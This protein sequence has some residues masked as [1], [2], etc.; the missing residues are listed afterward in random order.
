MSQRVRNWV[1]TL[2]NY[3]AADEDRLSMLYETGSI[4]YLVFGREVGNTG[5][6]H[7]QGFVQWKE[8]QSLRQCK[9]RIGQ[10]AHLEIA[11]GTPREAASYCKKDG[12]FVEFGEEPRGQGRRSDLDEFREWCEQ[13]TA[14]PP[15]H[16]IIRRFPGL[17]MR[18][19]ARILDVV[20]SFLPRIPL[21]AE[22]T[23]LRPWQATLL[24]EFSGEVNDREIIFYVDSDGNK[25]KSF[26]CRYL[27]TKRDDVQ[28]LRVGKRDDLAHAID[29]LKSIFVF[30]VQRSEMQF[31]Q[32]S[33]LE[34]LKDRMIFSPKYHSLTK[35]LS[36]TPFVVV[37]S[38][39]D[40]DME[41]L[42]R[43]RYDIRNL[44]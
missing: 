16:E 15:T 27:L 19:G 40:P 13:L 9:E 2:N 10:R 17:W 23:Q 38:N 8:K 42:S 30:D 18:S 11:R 26:F 20:D 29:P 7:L 35:I 36:K 33:V 43:D 37:F 6:R 21:V 3:N 1:F 14:R 5:T 25:G 4:K 24:E 28:V 22:E 34:M 44:E 12:E 39:E 31:L 32:Y 41:K